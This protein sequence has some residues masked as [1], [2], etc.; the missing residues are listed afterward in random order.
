MRDSRTRWAGSAVLAGALALVLVAVPGAGTA[1]AEQH[2]PVRGACPA[3]VPAGRFVDVTPGSVHAGAIDCAAWWGIARGVG[4]DRYAPGGDVLR[5][6]MASFVAR[7]VRGSGGALPASPADAFTDDGG[8]VHHYATNRLAAVGVLEGLGDGTYRPRAPVTRGQM[9]SI[10]VRSLEARIGQALPAAPRDH[11]ADDAGSVHEQAINKAAEAGLALGVTPGRFHPTETVTR[12]QGASFLARGL[13]LL[14]DR[15]L[16]RDSPGTLRAASAL[17]SFTACEDLL[18]HLKEEALAIVGPYGLD[19]HNLG[20]FPQ[21]PFVD[22]GGGFPEPAPV[23]TPDSEAPAA[24]EPGVDF[25]D[26]NVQEEGVDEADLVKTDGRQLLTVADG[27]LHR[28]DVT[29]AGP[30]A[31]GSLPVP[32]HASELLLAGDRAL[33]LSRDYRQRGGDHYEETGVLSLVDVAEG[34]PMQVV[35]TLEL[36]GFALSARM[37]EG[38]AR[39]VVNSA[40]ALPF[41][42]PDFTQPD[43]EAV[44]ARENRVRVEASTAEDWLPGYTRADASG[45][46]VEQGTLLDCAQVDRPPEFSG[47]NLLSVVTVD[48]AESF[49]PDTSMGLL[50]TGQTVYASPTGLYVATTR[51]DAVTGT[52]WWDTGTTTEIH[53][54]DIADTRS[55]SYLASGKVEG[56]TLNQFAL[57][58]HD[59]VLRVATTSER[60]GQT[61]ESESQVIVL[62]AQG[63]TLEEVGRVGG[64]GQ[65]E[66]IQAVRFIGDIGYVV[67]FRQID[68]LYTIDLSDPTAPAVLG[69]LKILGYSAYLHPVGEGLLLGVGVD[70][71]EAGTRLG[72]QVSLFDV[73]DPADPRRLHQATVA[74]GFSEVEF[75]HRA[76]LWWGPT[77]RAVVPLSIHASGAEPGPEDGFV[78]VV[79]FDVDADAGITE[80]GR[81]THDADH[82]AGD[83]FWSVPA[84]RRSLVVG[85]TLYT[86]SF[87][88][89]QAS[90]LSTLTDRGW[91]PFEPPGP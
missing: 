49:A 68:P 4:D 3:E 32:G 83:P 70:A 42:F 61:A 20:V 33:V 26:T 75:D 10:L 57:S 37:V 51:W 85:D 23:G 53:A 72:T 80:A 79:G 90:D 34:Q 39:V 86:V 6:Q 12:G 21:R 25:S 35:E 76:F 62:A 66:R 16:V 38:V 81:V 24:P 64:L 47:L 41:A 44:A 74:G 78:G 2:G 14:V 18:G 46:V 67:T 59:G 43:A 28:T 54:F 52:D 11:F 15:G 60:A 9:A 36:D 48:L 63:T 58:E 13:A 55:T 56:F 22:D 7:L 27:R 89:V 71:D 65:G 30:I 8:S 19:Q 45:T 1:G 77:G 50:A 17:R 82:T 40:P 91:V 69:E 87:A 29:G 84:I 5:A 88:G 73:S 31:A